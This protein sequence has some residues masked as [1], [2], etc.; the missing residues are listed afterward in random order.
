MK[1]ISFNEPFVSGKEIEY[2]T[3]AIRSNHISGDGIFTK[4]CQ[5][6]LEEK[7]HA[8]KILLV[9]SCTAALELSALILDLQ[10]DD[11]VI[12][13]SYTFVST[14]N[15]F[16][17]RRVKPIF[18]DIDPITLN[19]DHNKIEDA[20]S[21]RTKAIV[22]VHYAGVSCEMNT[23]KVIAKK[24]GL[25]IVEDAAQAVNS[26]YH[27]DYLG[28]LGD[29][30]TYSFHE[31]KNFICGEGGAIVINDESLV[32]KAEII[33]EKGTN[34]KEFFR[35]EVDKYTWCD[36]GSSYLPS[37]ILA[38]YLFA[39]LENIDQISSK[40][41]EIYDYYYNQLN[42]LAVNHRIQIPNIPNYCHHNH[43]IFFLLLNDVDQRNDFIDY[44][45]RKGIQCVFHY[46]PLHSS[47][48]G[49]KFG[50]VHGDLPVTESISDRIVRLPLHLN[51]TKQDQE[52]I[53]SGILD[54]FNN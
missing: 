43:Q 51:L 54:F 17:L 21:V 12:M 50:Y 33:R 3:Q 4:K 13:P 47:P 10:E 53:I 24:Y 7:F 29:L 8:K 39:Q 26:R 36:I 22:P 2:I 16:A 41:K 46:I 9:N 52:R 6:L 19:I 27:N 30:G 42:G 5:E 1:D 44:M 25:K 31:T 40:R 35:G 38:A 23:I 14:A 48:I 34:R 45:N 20:I 11:E 18:V 32:H 15:A 37:D 49:Q 28:T